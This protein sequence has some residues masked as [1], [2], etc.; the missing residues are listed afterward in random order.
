MN[1]NKVTSRRGRSRQELLYSKTVASGQSHGFYKQNIANDQVTDG[2]G[3]DFEDFDCHSCLFS[4]EKGIL[5]AGSE[6]KTL[7]LKS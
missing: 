4:F 5:R 3:N 7:V 6:Y 1:V 2:C